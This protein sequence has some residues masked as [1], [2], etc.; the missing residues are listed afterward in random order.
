[1]RR[2]ISV[3]L[4]SDDDNPPSISDKT[5]DSRFVASCLEISGMDGENLWHLIIILCIYCRDDAVAFHSVLGSN[6]R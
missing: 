6:F 4:E 1:M 2:I 3:S 5:N